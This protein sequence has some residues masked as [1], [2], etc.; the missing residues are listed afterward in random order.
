MQ[1]TED[2]VHQIV[3]AIEVLTDSRLT[4]WV[5]G[6][7]RSCLSLLFVIDLCTF[8]TPILLHGPPRISWALMNETRLLM[9]IPKT[10]SMLVRYSV[11]K[12]D[13]I[14]VCLRFYTRLIESKY[15]QGDLTDDDSDDEDDIKTPSTTTTET[16][17]QPM[18]SLSLTNDLLS[19]YYNLYRQFQ[20]SILFEENSTQ[21]EQLQALFKIEWKKIDILQLKHDYDQL[22]KEHQSTDEKLVHL[23]DE[24]QRIQLERDQL[25][26]EKIQMAQEIDRLKSVTPTNV[27]IQSD[28]VLTN[29]SNKKN[30]IDQLDDLL[31]HQI[32]TEQAKQFIQEI[33]YQQT[34]FNISNIRKSI[35]G[36]LKQLGSDLY[37]S[38]V[39]FLHELIQV[40]SIYFQTEIYSFLFV[41]K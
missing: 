20:K 35:C 17:I 16:I 10:I 13:S 26:R 41:F 24:L 38:S 34:T 14:D 4:Q 18:N 8:L 6:E 1:V 19:S 27:I 28:Q 11:C 7:S 29:V 23:R 21:Q 25:Q 2:D 40:N 9:L 39:H 31:P 22:K 5:R 32:T 3:E 30:I 36:S 12:M 33:Y 37:S 15:K